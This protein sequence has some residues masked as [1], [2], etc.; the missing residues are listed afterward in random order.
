MEFVQDPLQAKKKGSRWTNQKEPFL[1]SKKIA[2][3]IHLP[4]T[5]VRDGIGTLMAGLWL[6]QSGCQGFTGPFPLPFL[7][8][9]SLSVNAQRL[10]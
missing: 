3:L 10:I 8:N 2:P 7:M 6:P 9:L 4:R 1:Q 5:V